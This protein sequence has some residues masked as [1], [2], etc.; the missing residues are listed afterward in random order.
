MFEDCDEDTKQRVRQELHHQGIFRLD[1]FRYIQQKWLVRSA[2]FRL[3][4]M[5]LTGADCNA[6]LK[7]ELQCSIAYETWCSDAQPEGM[8]VE[9]KQLATEVSITPR[10]L[11]CSPE[12]FAL[13]VAV[14]TRPLRAF[15]HALVLSG[16]CCTCCAQLCAWHVYDLEPLN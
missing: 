4:T 5:L 3:L 11:P 7:S 13:L 16:T 1:K 2:T 14:D 8:W 15:W 10:D 6:T 9:L 12:A